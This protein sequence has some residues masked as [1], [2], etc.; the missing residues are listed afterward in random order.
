MHFGPSPALYQFNIKQSDDLFVKKKRPI[1]GEAI[2][3]LIKIVTNLVSSFVH[4]REAA[5]AFRLLLFAV[6][7]FN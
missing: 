7:L 2:E 3:S 6:S 1:F 5:I 4:T